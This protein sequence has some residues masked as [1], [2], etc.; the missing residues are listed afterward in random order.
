MLSVCWE[1]RQSHCDY[2]FRDGLLYLVLVVVVILKEAQDGTDAAW[3]ETVWW[4]ADCLYNQYASSGA[5]GL[6]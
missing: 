6:E 4:I 5:E 1:A 2:T 3:A